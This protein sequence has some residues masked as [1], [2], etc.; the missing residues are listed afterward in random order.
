MPHTDHNVKIAVITAM[1]LEDNVIPPR[2]RII[3]LQ[4]QSDA[5]YQL[6]KKLTTCTQEMLDQIYN[7]IQAAAD[8]AKVELHISDGTVCSFMKI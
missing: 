2:G 6:I 3:Y 7:L 8:L 4:M 5:L 1:Q